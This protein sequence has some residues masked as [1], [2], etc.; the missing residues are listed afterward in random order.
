[1]RNKYAK[2]RGLRLGCVTRHTSHVTRHTS[3]VLS[4]HFSF[5]CETHEAAAGERVEEEEEY[6]VEKEEEEEEEE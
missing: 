1:M 3:H 6:E 4:L 2:T 5:R